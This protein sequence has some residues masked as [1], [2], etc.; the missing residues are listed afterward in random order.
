MKKY[1]QILLPVLITAIIIVA[2]W[3]CNKGFLDK[4]PIGQYTIETYFTDDA[5]AFQAVVG[6]YDVSGWDKTFDRMFWTL[7]DGG[8]DDSNFGMNRDDGSPPF[9]DINP[10]TDYT[11]VAAAK[12]SPAFENM[13]KGFY[14]GI[15]RANIAINGIEKSPV[16]EQKK[17][18]FIAE[19]KALRAIYYFM[20]VNYYGGVP[21]FTRPINPGNAEDVNI[22]RATARQVYDQ[23]EKD[24]T[25]AI[26]ALPA[27][28]ATIDEK[29][30]GRITKGAAGTLLAKVY[31]FDKKYT[32]AAA[33]AQVVISSGEYDL[34]PDY[35]AN[36]VQATANG[37]E[38]VWE[39]QRV[40]NFTDNGGGWGPDSFD[41][42]LTPI[43]VGCGNG[44]WGQNAP[45]GDLYSQFQLSDGRRKYTAT[46][47]DDVL[48]GVTMCGNAGAPGMGK[49]VVPG[50]SQSDY[51]RYDI[52]PLNWP[53][54]RF[55]DVLLMRSE[56]LMSGTAPDAATKDAAIDLLLKV[57]KR[58]GLNS[59]SKADYQS[60]TDVELLRQIRNERRLELG[61]EAWRLFDLRRWG[62]DSLKTALIRV[63][64]INTTTR[65][66]DEAYLLYP[67][68]QSEIE[69]SKG[70]VKQTPGYE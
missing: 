8:S 10:V 7:G 60:Y 65:P 51:K 54:F 58:A 47:T 66:W 4:K 12:F 57:R 6:V 9:V 11:N 68:P 29:M 45:S 53:L 25:E 28:Q 20:L 42:T 31:L 19:C 44:M 32:E 27:K 62:A 16:S 67:V 70:A 40:E 55:S 64:K 22:P 36:F 23:I 63:G 34:N 37:I 17:T 2:V 49:H 46:T 15:N 5:K 14:E 69:L 59:P 3:G 50:K 35:Y 43:R 24:L 41:G 21:L 18:R 30:V 48:Q 33:A 38:S 61:M 39:I 13:Y 26:P 1:K 52:I 56:A